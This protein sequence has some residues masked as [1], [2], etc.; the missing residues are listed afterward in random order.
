M[1]DHYCFFP[2]K[3]VIKVSLTSER[4]TI[5]TLHSSVIL[6]YFIQSHLKF[7]FLKEKERVS[8]KGQGWRGPGDLCAVLGFKR[9]RRAGGRGE[10]AVVARWMLARGWGSRCSPAPR[11]PPGTAHPQ[12]QLWCGLCAGGHRCQS[13]VSRAGAGQEQATV[14]G[15]ARGLMLLPTL[16]RV[17]AR[18]PRGSRQRSGGTCGQGPWRGD[19]W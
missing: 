17:G 18:W 3:R 6:F 9:G 12:R 14:P 1:K 10:L 2:P 5:I 19:V 16:C 7:V 11:V 4:N 15:R 13:R 8:L